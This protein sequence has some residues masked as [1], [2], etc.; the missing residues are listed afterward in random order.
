MIL[1]TRRF[2]LVRSEDPT[3]V[4]GV[5]VIADGVMFGDGV[6]VLR[7]RPLHDGHQSST[8]IW[9]GVED[10]LKVHGHDGKTEIEWI[11]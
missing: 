7:W 1:E 5:G 6:V 11:D 9:P 8:A 10:M 3:G 4:S 2:E